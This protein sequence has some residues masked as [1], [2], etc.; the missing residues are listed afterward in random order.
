[1]YNPSKINHHKSPSFPQLNEKFFEKRGGW[2]DLP[3]FETI[4]TNAG[5]QPKTELQQLALVW[6]WLL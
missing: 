6:Q 3:L 1:M 4:E 2:A 5:T